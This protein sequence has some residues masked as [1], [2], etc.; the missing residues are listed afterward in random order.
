MFIGAAEKRMMR[1]NWP[2]VT[3]T[4]TVQLAVWPPFPVAVMV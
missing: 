3:V 1:G 2:V 4:P